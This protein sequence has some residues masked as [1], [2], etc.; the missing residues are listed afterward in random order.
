MINDR[1]CVYINVWRRLEEMRRGREG[2]KR[3]LGIF[4]LIVK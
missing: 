1:F 2:A 3:V 4:S